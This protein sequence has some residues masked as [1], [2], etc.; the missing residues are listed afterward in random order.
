MR[1]SARDK[2][3]TDWQSVPHDAIA[4][5]RQAE[6]YKRGFADGSAI[7]FPSEYSRR[8]YRRI[9]L[10]GPV[11]A[12]PIAL[13]R[14][15]AERLEPHG[16]HARRTRL[17]PSE[18]GGADAVP[19]ARV[20]RARGHRTDGT[21]TRWTESASGSSRKPPQTTDGSPQPSLPNARRGAAVECGS[22]APALGA[23]ACR[24]APL[25][26]GSST[27]SH[28]GGLVQVIG[29][30]AGGNP[31]APD[32]GRGRLRRRLDRRV[33]HR[34]PAATQRAARVQEH[35]REVAAMSDG[36]DGTDDK[37]ELTPLALRKSKRHYSLIANMSDGAD[38]TDD[39]R[40][41]LADFF[42]TARPRAGSP[43]PAH[44]SP[45]RQRGIYR[46]ADTS[47]KC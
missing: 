9:G 3:R 44:T 11:I 31:A 35:R 2:R 6:A 24:R 36:T 15:I 42:V 39:K 27:E 12:D 32:R 47:P 25:M 43:A 19:L 23:A 26:R 20:T 46:K 40:L 30:R 10:D 8:H 5:G 14:V 1:A 18:P 4:G 13:D 45:T 17:L 38:G 33:G 41:L 16:Q 22:S 37:R 21:G 34:E 7:I 29:A 28:A